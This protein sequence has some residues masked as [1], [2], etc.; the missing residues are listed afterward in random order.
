MGS[1]GGRGGG[2]WSFFPL[3][4]SRLNVK[5]IKL[6]AGRDSPETMRQNICRYFLFSHPDVCTNVFGKLLLRLRS[7]T[8]RIPGIRNCIE[9]MRCLNVI[10]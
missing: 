5:G 3:Q 9:K 7:T 10:L 6:S 8:Y 2:E 4:G 1:G